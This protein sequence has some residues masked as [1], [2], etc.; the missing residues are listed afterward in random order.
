MKQPLPTIRLVRDERRR[1]ALLLLFVSIT[2][3]ARAQKVVTGTVMDAA[4][5]EAL[6]GATIQVKETNT[7]A[8][9]DAEGRYRLA[10]PAAGASPTLVF[11]FIGYQPLE[12]AVGNR[13]VVDARLTNADNASGKT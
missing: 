7:G 4:S 10:L 1:W 5:G 11:S 8:T 12:I 3:S 9:T 6:A 13:T 2:W